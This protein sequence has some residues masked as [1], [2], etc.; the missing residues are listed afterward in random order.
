MG[1]DIRNTVGVGIVKMEGA[2]FDYMVGDEIW[3]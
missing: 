3:L 1:C 2:I